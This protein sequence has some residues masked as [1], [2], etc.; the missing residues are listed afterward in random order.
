MNWEI[1]IKIV[2]ILVGSVAVIVYG[3]FFAFGRDNAHPGDIIDYDP[4]SKFG[5]NNVLVLV[6]ICVL[7]FLIYSTFI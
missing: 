7:S 6:I 4:P 2:I 3:V 5:W 1:L